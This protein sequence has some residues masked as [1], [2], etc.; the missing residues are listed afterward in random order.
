MTTKVPTALQAVASTTYCV[1]TLVNEAREV[2]KDIDSF[3]AGDVHRINR[4]R[5]DAFSQIEPVP[6][7]AHAATR[8]NLTYKPFGDRNNTTVT[9]SARSDVFRTVQGWLTARR[10]EILERELD[11]YQENLLAQAA[12]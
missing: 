3:R 2:C 6:G 11:Q 12:L 1:E 10:Q 9:V 4:K 8:V 5:L 7:A